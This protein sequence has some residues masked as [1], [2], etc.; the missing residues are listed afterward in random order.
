MNDSVALQN[1]YLTFDG[2]MFLHV[3]TNCRLQPHVHKM[4]YRAQA[5]F[6]ANICGNFVGD[7]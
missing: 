6:V 2:M 3:P 1:D 5:F 7:P 4:E